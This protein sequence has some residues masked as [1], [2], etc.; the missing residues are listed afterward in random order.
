MELIN[1]YSDPLFSE[2]FKNVV[3]GNFYSDPLFKEITGE[4]KSHL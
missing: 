3:V 4:T 1:F 2:Q